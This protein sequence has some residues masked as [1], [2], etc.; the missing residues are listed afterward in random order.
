MF[1]NLNT[2]FNVL[3]LMA[4]FLNIT[5]NVISTMHFTQVLAIP[6]ADDFIIFCTCKVFLINVL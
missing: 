1:L 5:E 3:E 6:T 4:A 2:L